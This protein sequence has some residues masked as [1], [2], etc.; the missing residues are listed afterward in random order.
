MNISSLYK[1]GKIKGI[2]I[3]GTG[4]FT[5]PQYFEEL[6]EKLEP[7]EEGL[8]RLKK[9][10]AKE[11]DNQIAQNLRDQEIRFILTVEISN[12]YKRHGSARRLHNIVIMPSFEAVSEFNS[13]LGRIGNLKSDGRPILGL[14][15]RDLLEI[16]LETDDNAYF[17]P[18]HIWTPW[19]AMFGSKSGFDSIEEAF[20]DLADEIKT[21]ETGLSSDPFMN[22]RL[23]QLDGV[24]LVSN[25]DAHSPAKMGREA[26][27]YQG[28]M[29]YKSLIHA[30]KT[31]N[32]DWVGTI[33]FFPEEGKYHADGHKKCGVNLR[34]EKTKKL[35]GICPKCGKQLTIGV[36]NRVSELADRSA[37]HKPKN[38]KTVEYIIPLAEMIAEIEGV[39][40]TNSKTV[41]TKYNE[42]LVK[43]GDEFSI[44]RS[45]PVDEIK[46]HGF[47]RMSLAIEKMRKKDVHVVP[48]YD[49]VFG[50]V[51]VLPSFA[52]APGS[53]LEM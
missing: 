3:I 36:L 5:H 38:H 41:Q 12:I 11:Q 20:G 10:F 50:V 53:C 37:D 8:F 32:E 28:K 46:K 2:N 39:K 18:A 16:V 40:S 24:T 15:S 34:P 9:K 17:I 22:W 43:L 27:I 1:W 7:A 23:S 6:Q 26:N 33:E 51:R 4:D 31:G 30:M 25:S 45:V 13:R 48:G 52:N 21:V 49:G 44:L 47:E 42:M 29:D 14:D 19:F 35:N